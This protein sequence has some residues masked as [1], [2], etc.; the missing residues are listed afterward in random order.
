MLKRL[1]LILV[2][3]FAFVFPVHS[4]SQTLEQEHDLIKYI[5]DTIHDYVKKVDWYQD[6]NYTPEM[7]HIKSL[8]TKFGYRKDECFTAMMGYEAVPGAE[9]IPFA[10]FVIIKGKA[11][12]VKKPFWKIQFNLT[13]PNKPNTDIPKSKK[14]GI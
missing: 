10:I 8:I 4:S 7:D 14:H 9:P 13:P 3:M 2:L 12:P 6:K 1:A 5:A 11:D